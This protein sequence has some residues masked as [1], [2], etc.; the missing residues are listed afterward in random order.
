M[1]LEEYKT[2]SNWLGRLAE[3]TAK[4]NLGVYQTWYKWI[5]MNGGDFKD[6]TPDELIMYQRNVDNSSRYDILDNIIQPYI[7]SKTGRSGYKRRVYNCIKSFFRH[8]RAELPKDPAYIIRGDKPKVRGDLTPD[9][10]RRVVLSS[11]PLYQAVFLSLMQGGMGLDELIYWSNNGWAELKEQLRNDPQIVKIS[12]VGRKSRKFDYNYNTLIGKDAIQAIRNY[13]SIRPERAST[14]FI[15]QNG[16]SL[17][18][19]AVKFYWFRHLKKLGII[20]PKK[21]G[22]GT[23]YGKNLHEIRDVF[24][25]LWEK[26]PAKS[27]VGEFCMGHKVDPLEY[28]K[29]FRDEKWARREYRK[30]L[31][32]LNIL[33]SARPFGQIDED[34]VESQERK[35]QDLVAE[36]ARLK[37][38][39]D[40][41]ALRAEVEEL[42]AF[43]RQLDEFM[44]DASFGLRPGEERLFSVESI[45]RVLKLAERY[46]KDEAGMSELEIMLEKR[47]RDQE[48]DK[49]IKQLEREGRV[50]TREIQ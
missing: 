7:S 33:S 47:R 40:Y 24:R 10:I 48:L 29:A 20:K 23:R 45:G 9:E 43:K 11:N 16:E 28:N 6:F 3:S 5:R 37:S 41:E 44:T 1:N 22:P 49:R 15:T 35:I 36:V 2:V 4:G 26:S 30:A 32:F 46:G 12:L 8:N 50:E 38:N 14:I 34:I 18:K 25:S 21:E 13:L 19:T 31:P 27:S 17:T 42:T 39:T